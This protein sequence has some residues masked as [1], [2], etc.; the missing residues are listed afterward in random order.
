MSVSAVQRWGKFVARHGTTGDQREHQDHAD[1]EREKGLRRQHEGP[2]GELK[3]DLHIKMA[4]SANIRITLTTSV[5]KD[6]AASMKGR[7]AS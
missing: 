5:R 4:I 1:H 2:F 6:C 3:A 7:S